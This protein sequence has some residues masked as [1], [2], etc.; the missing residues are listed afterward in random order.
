MHTRSLTRT[1]IGGFA[2]AILVPAG[3][4]VAQQGGTGETAG[5]PGWEPMRPM[6]GG[7][8]MHGRHQGMGSGAP[9]MHGGAQPCLAGSG[10]TAEM[11]WMDRVDLS[12]E[13]RDRL[14]ALH[15]RHQREALE[16]RGRVRT[17]HRVLHGLLHAY[18]AD[19]AAVSAAFDRLSEARKARLLGRLEARAEVEAV[20]TESQRLQL[21]GLGI[22]PGAGHRMKHGGGHGMKHGGRMGMKHPGGMMHQKG[23]MGGRGMGGHGMGMSGAGM[24]G[25]DMG[26]QG[27]GMSGGMGMGMGCGAMMSTGGLDDTDDGD[28]ADR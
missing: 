2:L 18:D 5:S 23:M 7:A 4:V 12:Q 9:M 10:A 20:L 13:Q 21:R 22:G 14:M 1:L 15:Q 25:H 8:M 24:G 3:I 19:P 27:M 6:A 17:A 26:G 11:A 28:D 16:D